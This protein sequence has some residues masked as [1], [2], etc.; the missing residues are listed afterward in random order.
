MKKIASLL[1][2]GLAL[3]L[4]CTKEGPVT[5]NRIEDL[6]TVPA[7]AT[8][9]PALSNADAT[10]TGDRRYF[11]LSFGT[12]LTTRLVGFDA[13]L[14]AGQ[15]ILGADEIG[16]AV[17]ANT[18]VNGADAKE[19]FITV[20]EKDGKYTIT[21]QIDGSVL[22]W[23]GELPF[24]PD[25]DPIEL[26]TVL[27]AKSN[28]P[29][30]IQSVTVQLA[31][32]GVSYEWNAQTYSGAWKGNGH[33]LALDL[34][35]EDGYLHDGTYKAS[36]EG[37]QI[38]A[39][40]FGIGYDGQITY[41]EQVYPIPNQGTC[42][43][44]VADGASDPTAAKKITDGV[45][46]VTSRDIVA[47]GEEVTV[48][49]IFWGKDYPKEIIFEGAIPDLTKPK[50]EPDFAHHYKE[51]VSDIYDS[52]TSEII[53]GVKK[54]AVTV[55][56]AKGATVAYFEILLAEGEDELEGEFPSTSYASQ[57]GQLA[58]GWEF[59]MGDFHMAGGSY[60]MDELGQQVYMLAT[61]WSLKVTKLIKGAYVFEAVS[62]GTGET[63]FKVEASGPDYEE[64]S[65][66]PEGGEGGDAYDGVMLTKFAN[67][68]DYTGWGMTMMAVEFCT[69][70]LTPTP[71]FFGATYAG[72]GNYLK[73]EIY[74]TAAAG[75]AAGEYVPNEVGTDAVGEGQFKAGY[76]P[77][78]GKDYGSCWFTVAD[79]V[80][81]SKHITDGK[82]T[83]SK[84]GDNYIIEVVST[85]VKCKYVGPLE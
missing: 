2:L 49:T 13:L 38:K 39:G 27:S 56:N 26:S 68:T 28:L 50:R 40:E 82:V 62:A 54:H 37:G 21:A 66:K 75:I 65:Y 69:D 15:Y 55:S 30:N 85:A 70:G 36:A 1:V 9:M 32:A 79:G 42:F 11:D 43:F 19:G 81:T 22:T 8:V 57:P 52:Q 10:W 16:K 58:D 80:G 45:F 14:P 31:S 12:A 78:G 48:W 24:L 76:D 46:T 51:D 23:N 41:G 17:L 77:E 35:S 7:D 20:N 64:G 44:D 47:L 4:S 34:Y 18:K 72:S 25:P 67:K 71:G 74:A 73:L 61:E 3:V 59:S 5:V 84:D 83:V 53:A 63:V 33:Y 60:F 6:Y 29:G